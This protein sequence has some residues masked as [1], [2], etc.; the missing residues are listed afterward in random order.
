[1]ILRNTSTGMVLEQAAVAPT[2]GGH[3]RSVTH[4]YQVTGIVCDPGT[5]KFIKGRAIAWPYDAGDWE[6]VGE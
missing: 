5:S 6:E 4:W 2:N 1:M 3:P